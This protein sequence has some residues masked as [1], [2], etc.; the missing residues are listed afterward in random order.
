MKSIDREPKLDTIKVVFLVN[1]LVRHRRT[2]LRAVSFSSHM[3][4]Y[5]GQN[6]IIIHQG[7]C[8]LIDFIVALS[9][10]Q[11]TSSIFSLSLSLFTFF[12]FF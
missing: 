10:P 7:L 5:K 2:I 11:S 12:F 6:S 8:Y 9:A 3:K 4:I 1:T